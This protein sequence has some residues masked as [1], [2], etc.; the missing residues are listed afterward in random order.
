MKPAS[1]MDDAELKD[2]LAWARLH[3]QSKRLD[4]RAKFQAQHDELDAEM[5]SRQRKP[6][7]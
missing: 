6:T 1:E 5:K 7:G 2:E 4:Q 3:L